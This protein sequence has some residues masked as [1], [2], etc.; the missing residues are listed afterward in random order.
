MELQR[1]NAL[2]VEDNPGDFTLVRILFDDEIPDSNITHAED[3]SDAAELL[4]INTFDIIFLD[5]TLPDCSG[6]ELV[7]KVVALAPNTPILILTGY[8]DKHYGVEALG[9]GISDY[10]LKDEL[11]GEQLKKTVLYN[12]ERAKISNKLRES[13]EKYRATF[14]GSPLPMWVYDSQSYRFL[15]VNQAAIQAYGFSH[16]EFLRMTFGDLIPGDDAGS[17]EKIIEACHHAEGFFELS[18][19]HVTRQQEIIRVELQINEIAFEKQ[20]ARLML[21]HDI[22]EKTRIEEALKLSELRFKALVQKGSDVFS[23]HNRHGLYLYTGD[24]ALSILGIA[25]E[26]LENQSIFSFIHPEDV[27]HVREAFQKVFELQ[28][29][30]IQPYRFLSPAGYI[31]LETIITDMTDDLSVAGIVAN[32]KNVS[33]KIESDI[34]LKK[35]NERFN[36]VSRATSDIIWD[37]DLVTGQV[38]WNRGLS[39]TFGYPKGMQ[40]TTLEWTFD[41]IHPDDRQ[42]VISGIQHNVENRIHLWQEEY[43]FLCNNGTYRHVFDRGFFKFDEH[44]APLR[45]IGAMQD[46]TQLKAEEQRLKLLES[47]VTNSSDAVILFDIRSGGRERTAFNGEIT[48]VN[49]VFTQITGIGKQEA[50]GRSISVLKTLRI[51]RKNL[52]YSIR[53][54]RSYKPFGF[55]LSYSNSKGEVYFLNLYMTPVP[56]GYRKLTHWAA[57]VSD[58]TERT[59]KEQEITKAIIDAQELERYEIGCELHDNINQI[60]SATQLALGMTKDAE[61]EDDVRRW[62]GQASTYINLAIDE[63]RRLSHRLAPNSLDGTTFHEAVVSLVKS[64]NINKRTNFTLNIDSEHFIHLGADV[65]INL[66]RIIQEQLNNIIKHAR[67]ANVSIRSEIA[68]KELILR[69]KDDGIG[70]NIYAVKKGIGLNNIMK[71]CEII[72]ARLTIHSEINKGCELLISIE[73]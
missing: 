64:I 56:D 15:D 19:H 17:K 71:R 44:N 18:C 9:L 67:A 54:L 21:A 70:F 43:R 45:F 25:P 57:I 12:I 16:E 69:I 33:D 28:S 68:G 60:L 46:T 53:S 6:N 35:S 40:H 10:L 47:V 42:K 37:C 8:A 36:I 38:T 62:V 26:T 30:R 13:E 65:Q 7:S 3:F 39:K 59:R 50:T 52:I 48:Y 4:R 20:K 58:I 66:Y 24:N 61:T 11:N 27:S 63:I 23:I 49:D 55:E 72:Q 32:S 51:S 29:A 2:I 41:K 1:L 73:S 5:L 34:K 31:W 22:T 14:Y